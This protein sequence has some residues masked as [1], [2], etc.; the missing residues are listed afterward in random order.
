MKNLLFVCLCVFGKSI[1]G[2]VILNGEIVDGL[3][4]E[5][6]AYVR[7]SC[8]SNGENA[9][10]NTYGYF[11]LSLNKG[12]QR[13]E[14]SLAGYEKQT[15]FLNIHK[16]TTVKILL[17][18]YAADIDTVE[19]T[20]LNTN[21]IGINLSRNII[22]IKEMEKMPMLAGEADALKA[23]QF[24][25]GVQFGREGSSGLIVR[26]GSSE[27]NLILLDD[28]PIY[29]VSHLFGF[30]SLFPPSSLK[31]A[32][33]YKG[34]FPAEYG[35]RL[36]SV[37]NLQGK[38]GNMKERQTS[39]RM[40]TISGQITTE[41]PLIKNKSSYFVSARRTWIDLL[42]KPFLKRDF[43][44]SGVSGGLGYGFYDVIAKANYIIGDR[45]RIYVSFYMGK[46]KAETDIET[47]NELDAG[48]IMVNRNNILQWGNISGSIRY[49]KLIGAKWFLKSI[50]GYTGYG[51]DT[52]RFLEIVNTQEQPE[53]LT[54]SKL[55]FL[56]SIRDIRFKQL[57]NYHPNEKHQLSFGISGSNKLF[58]PDLQLTETQIQ[59]TKRDTLFNQDK[60]TSNTYSVYAEDTYKPAEKW[61]LR[62]GLRLDNFRT[63]NITS[64][65]LQPRFALKY[66]LSESRDLSISYS[67][68]QQYLHLLSN[69][70][71][72]LPADLWVP[73]TDK[74]PPS[75]SHQIAAGW[76]G[77]GPFESII[78]LEAYYKTFSSVIAYKDGVSLLS[79]FESWEN[80]VE[81]GKGRAYGFELW[82]RKPTGRLNGWLSYTLA[83]NNRQ[84]QQIN[85]GEIFP[86]KYDRRHNISLFLNYPIP[87]K[88]SS[89][90]L[91][92]MY[93]SGSWQ[94]VPVGVANVPYDLLT[95]LNGGTENI[96]T[97]AGITGFG[98]VTPYADSRNNYKLRPFHKLDIS[99][100]KTK[101]KKKYTRTWSYG[102]YNVYGR[103]NPY[104]IFYQTT[105]EY[106]QQLADFMIVNRLAEQ[107]LLFWIP[108]VSVNF[109]F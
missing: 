31:S 19:I 75:A 57:F 77:A 71:L 60:F 53:E 50:V 27:Q 43:S 16:D 97:L 85:N 83:W 102:M 100:Q 18:V 82:A 84:F 87:Q 107:S 47:F 90:S 3:N 86:F 103:R 15:I 52:S 76:S 65:S 20:D 55:S 36:S 1:F 42:V 48:G 38:E 91:T 24:L 51:F 101:V 70:G 63:E 108:Y 80:K 13:V 30:A 49:H 34:G 6:L 21:P 40:G 35:G 62:G 41:G 66:S 72:G 99:Y 93:M 98:N 56:S 7:V 32:E 105:L 73:A 12:L 5:A 45:D 94:T 29:N 54:S 64:Y 74:V 104:Y 25:P 78:T 109:E 28:I 37:V 59:G 92:W 4:G 23:M 2:Q 9:L 69:T 14:F 33:I 10:S 26:G 61:T 11:S 79:N 95:D 106:N 39:I 8:S 81:S 44:K 88:K 67:Y 96:L 17:N 46:D 89:L 68:I 22:S 58:Q